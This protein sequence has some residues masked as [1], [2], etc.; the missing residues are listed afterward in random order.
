[1]AVRERRKFGRCLV[2]SLQRLSKLSSV[3]L[4]W[5]NSYILYGIVNDKNI[6]LVCQTHWGNQEPMERLLKLCNM[7][8]AFGA[9]CEKC[10]LNLKRGEG[11]IYFNEG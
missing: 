7:F 5:R 6:F 1:M 2:V 3:V 10:E 4:S 11:I 9:I 8:D